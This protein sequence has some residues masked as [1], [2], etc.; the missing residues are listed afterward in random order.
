MVPAASHPVGAAAARGAGTELALLRPG[1]P[2]DLERSLAHFAR[3]PL[4]QVLS[5]PDGVEEE[6]ARGFARA[7]SAPHARSAELAGRRGAES[8]EALAV[9]AWPALER[10]LAL[11]HARILAVL[12]HD[13]LRVSLARALGFPLARARSVRVD[14]GRVVLLRDDS[15]GIVLRRSNVLSPEELAGTPLP[16]GP[17][18]DPRPGRQGAG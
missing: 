2:E 14:P 12:S 1:S 10:E 18:P 3:I 6:W 17:S 5:P 7:L 4:A 11:G 13:V 15:L 16:G 8:D 9:R